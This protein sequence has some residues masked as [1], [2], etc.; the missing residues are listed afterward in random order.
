MP[1]LTTL[2]I[3]GE[4][5]G[6]C[7][8]GLQTRWSRAHRW[9]ESAAVPLFVMGG[10]S[11]LVIADEGFDGLVVCIDV[12]GRTF[13]TD[14][15]DTLVTAV[16]ESRGTRS[17]ADCVGRGLAGLECLSGIP[18]TVGGTPIQNV[19]AYGQDV[20]GSIDH[21]TAYDRQTRAVVGL[22]GGDCGFAYRTSR[23]KG[24]DAGRFVILDVTYPAASGG[25]HRRRI[26]TSS[27]TWR[28][29]VYRRRTL[30]R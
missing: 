11:N 10:G 14:G 6:C 30:R 23:F 12:R 15:G 13:A 4:R 27:T 9:S 3:G 24:A 17:S 28:A 29:R 5:D 2:G 18:G 1:P 25:A 21:L 16:P 22:T 8:R 20:A 7:T 26:R 19:G